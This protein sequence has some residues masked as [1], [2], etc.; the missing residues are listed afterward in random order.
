MRR[1]WTEEQLKAFN[2]GDYP[3][4][5]I[6]V[7]GGV[8]SGK[9]SA[10]L[11]GFLFWTRQF[12]GKQFGLIAKTSLQTEHIVLRNLRE[13]ANEF[14]MYVSDKRGKTI[15]IG[16]NQFIMFDGVNVS[17]AGRIQGFDLAGMYVDEAVNIH[18]LVMEE[19]AN[20]IREEEF[21]KLVM[22]ANPDEPSHDFYIDFVMRA[23]EIGMRTIILNPKDNPAMSDR[24]LQRI[25]DTAVGGSYYQRVEGLWSTRK[26]LIFHSFFPPDKAPEVDAYEAFYIAVDPGYSSSTHALLIG[27]LSGRYWV[28]DELRLDFVKER[29]QL[30]DD[31]QADRIRAKFDYI[32]KKP[33]LAVVDSA[34]QSL[35]RA[36]R[37]KFDIAVLNSDKKDFE[38]SIYY[39]SAMLHL[40]VC[41]LSDNVE[42]LHRELLTFGFDEKGKIP[43]NQLSIHGVDALRYFL[44]TMREVRTDFNVGPL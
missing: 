36:I 14:G 31:E 30:S 27:K 35:R 13:A 39:T 11:A 32:P 37:Y 24:A 10:A 38:A 25:I 6:L 19:V 28:I 23:E 40:G 41:R 21:A 17:A 34:A 42:H 43:M 29:Y 15:T 8:G 2:L 3:E 33:A 7:Y 44:W 26:G 9:T 16:S 1:Y 18:P 20:R 22:T 12:K 4:D 5:F